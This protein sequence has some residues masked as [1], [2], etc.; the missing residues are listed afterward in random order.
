MRAFTFSGVV[1]V[2]LNIA[3]SVR[4]DSRC[5]V[6]ITE[7]LPSNSSVAYTM[8]TYQHVIDQMTN[9]AASALDQVFAN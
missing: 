3:G 1:G 8:D 6:V 5:G 7:R 9:Q 2:T 4:P